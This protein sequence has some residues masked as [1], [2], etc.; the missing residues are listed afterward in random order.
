MTDLTPTIIISPMITMRT[1]C[2]FSNSSFVCVHWWT[3]GSNCHH[4]VHLITDLQCHC[5]NLMDYCVLI[6]P[7][8]IHQ[9]CNTIFSIF[10]SFLNLSSLS[11]ITTSFKILFSILCLKFLSSS[12]I[13]ASV[14]ISGVS[15][16]NISL[17]LAFLN[18]TP[19][20]WYTKFV[21]VIT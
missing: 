1:S 14:T 7:P 10:S 4:L 13:S 12:L 6:I 17:P 19:S 3:V 8:F 16:Y 11:K 21:C 20:M 5:Q 15:S 9:H 18:L 2:L